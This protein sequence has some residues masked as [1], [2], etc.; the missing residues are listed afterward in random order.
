MNSET[1]TP[2]FVHRRGMQEDLPFSLT[3]FI[4]NKEAFQNIGFCKEMLIKANKSTVL[5]ISKGR[6][7]GGSVPNTAIYRIGFWA[8]SIVHKVPDFTTFSFM[9]MKVV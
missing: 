6:E 4:Y 9:A 1:Q 3:F 7:G 2:E 5:D 8:L